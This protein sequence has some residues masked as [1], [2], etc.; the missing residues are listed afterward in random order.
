MHARQ[1]LSTF[2]ILLFVNFCSSLS[3]S[4]LASYCSTHW[5]WV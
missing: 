5:Q 4:W 2:D 1:H 3:Y